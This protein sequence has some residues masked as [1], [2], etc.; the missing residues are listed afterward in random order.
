MMQPVVIGVG[1]T[2]FGR[3]SDS[4]LKSLAGGAA[5][6]ALA[7]AKVGKEEVGAIFAA[8]VGAGLITG[9]EGVR[10]QVSLKPIGL[11]GVPLFNVENACA[12]GSAALHL[13]AHYL[14][15]GAAETALVVGYE[16]MT[17][18]DK[19]LAFKA[20]EACGDVDEVAEIKAGL[21]PEGA[22]RSVFMDFYAA[23]VRGYL[24]STDC[25]KEHLAAIAA[26]N[27]TNG[28]ANP[29]AQFRQA[30]TTQEVMNSREIVDP[31]HLLM[32]SPISD[33]GAAV[34]L[35][36]PEWAKARGLDGPKIAATKLRSDS[37]STEVPQVRAIA[38]EAYEEAGITPTDVD[39]AEVH[40]GSAPG[41][42]FAY[43]ELGFAEKGEGWKLIE[44]GEVFHG[45]KRPVN[46]SGGLL[47]RGHPIGATGVAQVCELV[48][49]L[50]GDA[51][52]RQVTNARVAAA[53]CL[54]G[55]AS[56]GKTTG[57]AAMSIIVLAA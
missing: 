30:R 41:E 44:S 46:P 48:W 10:G 26:K 19:S 1:M 25:T 4:S 57:A 39:V 16:K 50:R 9:Q 11:G 53:H 45:G 40:D 32:C 43:E 38:Q 51:G 36:S 8:N 7:D 12:S 15:S 49:Q 35:A 29:Y 52:E 42:L 54:G 6:A 18:Q 14:A 2:Q 13:A 22:G 31:L 20:I 37:F 33:G 47:A 56:F 55:Q 17:A 34:L 24:E 23:K 5:E 3:Q 21:G 27:H 28:V